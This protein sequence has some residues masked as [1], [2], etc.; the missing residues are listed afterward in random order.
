MH[1]QSTGED[2]GILQFY[3]FTCHFLF[4]HISDRCMYICGFTGSLINIIADL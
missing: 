4:N 2:C 3:N 1:V